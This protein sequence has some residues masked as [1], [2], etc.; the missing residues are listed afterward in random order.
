MISFNDPAGRPRSRWFR[1]PPRRLA[2]AVACTVTAAFLILDGSPLSAEDWLDSF[3]NNLEGIQ[4]LSVRIEQEQAGSEKAA[5]L[6]KE[7][8]LNGFEPACDSL[9]G[10]DPA[11]GRIN[12][13]AIGV[14]HLKRGEIKESRQD[15]CGALDDFVSAGRYRAFPRLDARIEKVSAKAGEGCH[16]ATD[17]IGAV[18]RL[19][20]TEL[21]GS[22]GA[23]RIEP[24]LFENWGATI[25]LPGRQPLLN[26][27]NI[28][29]GGDEETIVLADDQ[30]P[31]LTPAESAAEKTAPSPPAVSAV[32]ERSSAALITGSISAAS[33]EPELPQP[34]AIEAP[35]P[36][37]TSAI[38][39]SSLEVA[40][41]PVEVALAVQRSSRQARSDHHE[42]VGSGASNNPLW[43]AL[44]VFL[45][46]SFFAY[47]ALR[48]VP[49]RVSA[50]RLDLARDRIAKQEAAIVKGWRPAVITGS[51]L[52]VPVEQSGT[53]AP[54]PAEI[55]S[56]A[57]A[58][59]ATSAASEAKPDLT[60][61]S[62]PTDIAAADAPG[63]QSP[64]SS[65]FEDITGRNSE[66]SKE[67]PRALAV[68]ELV[69]PAGMAAIPTSPE[70]EANP[71]SLLDHLAEGMLDTVARGTGSLVVID[72]LGRL[73]SN[74]RRAVR[75]ANDNKLDKRL[76]SIDP[77]NPASAGL[78][79]LFAVP[80]ADEDTLQSQHRFNAV[81]E[82]HCLVFEA[83]FGAEFTRN[84][85]VTLRHL[86]RLL[87]CY[88][89]ASLRTL[90]NLLQ[91]DSLG[92]LN[93][94]ASMLTNAA[95]RKFLADAARSKSL[96]GIAG[97]MRAKLDA[98][99]GDPDYEFLTCGLR[100]EGVLDAQISLGRLIVL[101]PD[102]AKYGPVRTAALVRACLSMIA[103]SRSPEKPAS[104]DPLLTC[105]LLDGVTQGFGP[106]KADLDFLLAEIR[107]SGISVIKV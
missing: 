6:H 67:P 91:A 36:T 49:A 70:A 8:I 104:T 12:D 5:F 103:L 65:Q 99:L 100:G 101:H 55:K 44:V 50:A 24:G 57:E 64:M 37:V 30:P 14:A 26:H 98:V 73:T 59:P 96:E 22:H 107:K 93:R 47:S 17:R 72:C 52:A 25:R 63:S 79:N 2:I 15:N 19:A 80:A 81:F 95:S 9:I 23:G 94:Y 45:V 1:N 87:H 40:A 48:A 105:V 58:S 38:K 20:A 11:V 89:G 33:S 85:R 27:P 21:A 90:R 69:V 41:T 43:A 54:E 32:P 18:A 88:P 86:V 31:M 83:I 74:I 102:P 62:C 75:E 13:W 28:M 7:C 4:S 35:A 53:P 29:L 77:Q 61:A 39:I 97:E 51:E 16:V 42:A 78:L 92:N 76:L 66:G 60:A 46:L 3:S 106:N 56:K 84:N 82:L 71:P 68:A 10:K 34:A